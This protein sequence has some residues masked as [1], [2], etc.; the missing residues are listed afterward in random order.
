MMEII[1]AI[2]Q[3]IN[4]FQQKIIVLQSDV[5]EIDFVTFIYTAESAII[6]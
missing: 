1:E 4:N 6:K 3:R 2:N 5:L